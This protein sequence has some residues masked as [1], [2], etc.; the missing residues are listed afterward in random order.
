MFYLVGKRY[1]HKQIRSPIYWLESL[2][3]HY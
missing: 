3:S 2:K 1:M